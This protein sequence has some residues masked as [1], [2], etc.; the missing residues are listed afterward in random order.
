MRFGIAFLQVLVYTLLRE[1]GDFMDFKD[2]LK[3]RRAELDLTLDEIGRYV[4][5][6]GAT[7]SR[8]E[9]GDIENIRRDKIAKLAEVLQVTP[10][11]L[12][13]W[14]ESNSELPESLPEEMVILNRAAKNMTPEQLQRLLNMAKLMFEEEF[15]FNDEHA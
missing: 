6:S 11:Y 4:G 8:W 3:N 7:V 14:P 13:G 9:K 12:M 15:D 10:A 2:I 5:V 1:R